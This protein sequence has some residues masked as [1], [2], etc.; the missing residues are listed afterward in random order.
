MAHYNPKTVLRQ[1]SNALLKEFIEGK[2][3]H[4]TV[5]WDEITETQV[6]GIYDEFLHLPE[7]ARR[8]IELDM[9][10][11]HAMASED[12]I[13]A[14]VET[15]RSHDRPIA[16]DLERHESRYDK[17]MWALLHRP[18]V[19]QDAVTFAHADRLPPRYW[20]KRNSLPKQPPDISAATAERLG[21]A[22]SAFFVQAEGRG[23]LSRVERFRRTQDLDYFFVYL[24]DYPDTTVT[25]NDDEQ[26]VRE[27][28]RHAFEVV[29][30]FDRSA[31]TL[32]MYARGGHKV[33]RPLQEIFADTVLGVA[34]DPE[35]PDETPYRVD[36]LKMRGFAFPTDPEDGITE[37][38]VRRLR[39]SVLGNPRKQFM[40]SRLDD[41]GPDAMYDSLENE[42]NQDNLP[43][44]LLRVERATI[45]MKLAGRGRVRKLTFE[46]G[47]K[48]CNLKGKSDELRELGEK[49][50]RRWGIEAA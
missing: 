1:V 36:D 48:S 32:D 20:E 47:P 19:W 15:G 6:Q 13:R 26:L 12:G 16:E 37:V 33:V 25:W 5:A 17:A 30:A 27:K 41:S 8:E 39:L 29:Y 10:D 9:Q 2:G 38:A 23:R 35:D 28:R 18:D 24:S 34:L 44:S 42:I 4:L 45:T 49:Y 3:H 46:V 50:L 43:L 7:R 14:L 11:V 31:G 21:Q 40:V 22:I